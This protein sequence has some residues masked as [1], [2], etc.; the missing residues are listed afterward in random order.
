MEPIMSFP[1]FAQ[2]RDSINKA[3]AALQNWNTNPSDIPLPDV[4]NTERTH[5][6]G[7]QI[8]PRYL[9][10]VEGNP[11]IDINKIPKMVPR[12]RID[13]ELPITDWETESVNKRSI[14]NCDKV[15]WEVLY[16]QCKTRPY[17]HF[18]GMNELHAPVKIDLVGDPNP[19]CLCMEELP[20][21]FVCSDDNLKATHDIWMRSRN[22][23]LDYRNFS[24]LK[25]DE[26]GNHGICWWNPAECPTPETSQIAIN[27]QI[28]ETIE[29]ELQ[30]NIYLNQTMLD[31]YLT[32][33][34]YNSKPDN[35]TYVVVS[36]Q[37]PKVSTPINT[38]II[39]AGV[40]AAVAGVGIISL[41]IRSA[42]D[43][44]NRGKK[45]DQN[46]QNA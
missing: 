14:Y 26:W 32:W 37:P 34:K 30:T 9:K 45:G 39:A 36:D 22:I 44:C 42:V 10:S 5:L 23:F 43:Y 8:A 21:F 4:V 16:Q 3:Y 6:T 7:E 1:V 25:K 41:T 33:R 29:N 40:A 18:K 27:R 46:L 19:D 2:A 13:Y 11:N 15:N 24:Y 17:F 31:D 38:G 28:D 20:I 12:D 35:F